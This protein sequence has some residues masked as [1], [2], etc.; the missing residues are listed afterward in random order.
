M[1]TS[2]IKDPLPG[3]EQRFPY[4]FAGYN[5]GISVPKGWASLF[6]KLCED[7]DATLG[8]DKRGFYWRQVKEKWGTGSF[9]WS[10][11]KHGAS[12]RVDLVGPAGVLSF[13][14]KSKLE[15]SSKQ[16]AEV[17]GVLRDLIQ[18]AEKK[19]GDTCIL[20]GKSPAAIDNTGG[21]LLTLCEEHAQMRRSDDDNLPSIWFRG[22]ES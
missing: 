7:V 6:T 11:G 2:E 16:E 18:A 17:A 12:V 3:L 1:N 5:L 21:Y 19:T 14:N 20:C 8:E 22:E 9:Y 4:Q 10:L 13:E 15:R